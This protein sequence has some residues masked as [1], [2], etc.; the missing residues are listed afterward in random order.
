MTTQTNARPPRPRRNSA[1]SQ[2]GCREHVERFLRGTVLLA[3]LFATPV[4]A[5]QLERFG[6]LEVHYM[7]LNTT[8]LAPDMTS[9]YDLPRAEN[10][11]LVNIAGRRTQADGNTTAVPLAIEGT[12]SNLVGQTRSLDFS[13]VQ[14]PDAIYYLATTTFTDRET[15][16]FTLEVTD[17]D[18]GRTH[19]MRFQKELWEQ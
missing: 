11:A 7:V 12:V 17:R 19:S 15:L 10:Q 16:R 14:D 6:D 3:A 18:T 13:E 9:R 4:G 2:T 5:E 1:A 8:T